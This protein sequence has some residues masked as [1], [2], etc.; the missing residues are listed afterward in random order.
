MRKAFDRAFWRGKYIFRKFFSRLKKAKK[1]FRYERVDAK[2][3]SSKN[4]IT[5]L[6]FNRKKEAFLRK[7]SLCTNGESNALLNLFFSGLSNVIFLLKLTGAVISPFLFNFIFKI[8]NNLK[9]N[10]SLNSLRTPRSSLPSILPIYRTARTKVPAVKSLVRYLKYFNKLS[11]I[12]NVKV[13]GVAFF[14]KLSDYGRRRVKKK[15]FNKNKINLFFYFFFNSM[16]IFKFNKIKLKTD[17]VKYL[18][19]RK[20]LIFFLRKDCLFF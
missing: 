6:F 20:K 5:R 3:R 13:L 19:R 18:Y 15:F 4:R 14:R 11:S 10:K 2:V 1:P 17:S 7:E 12:F 8:I 9:K 16:S